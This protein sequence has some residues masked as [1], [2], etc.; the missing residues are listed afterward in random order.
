MLIIDLLPYIFLLFITVLIPKILKKN[1]ITILGVIYVFFC[2][3]RYGVGWDYFNY[4]LT[5]KEGGWYITRMEFIVRQIA[6]LAHILDNSRIFFVI[7][8]LLITFFFFKTIN[9]LSVVPRDSIFIYLCLPAFFISSLTTVRFS[10]AIALLFYA[11]IFINKNWFLYIVFFTLSV[12]SHKSAIIGVFAIPFLC[13][14]LKINKFWN[15]FIFIISFL[16]S[17][18]Y[19]F[20]SSVSIV[21]SYI[22]GY[23]D[24]ISNI[25]EQGLNY[26]NNADSSG[27]SKSPY[28]YAFINVFN[29]FFYNRLTHNGGDNVA[30]YIT[31]YNLG[32]S[33]MFVLSFDQ[34]FA[35]RL[36]QPFIVYIILIAPFYRKLLNRRYIVYII[37]VFVFLFQLSVKGNHADFQL[38]RNCYLPYKI[39]LE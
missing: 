24:G 21:L 37:C 25:A 32:C 10:L 13:G 33:V 38:R 12:M 16:F 30:R 19:S 23:L 7:T 1:Y 5:I 4:I 34:V 17:Q 11:T 15:I 39:S 27:F 28:M 18:F 22:G 20:S 29:L 36:A 8:S 6:Y 9:K 35:S 2:G 14:T 3:F 26:L 31:L